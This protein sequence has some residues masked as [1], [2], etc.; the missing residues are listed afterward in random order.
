MNSYSYS[1]YA[2][3]SFCLNYAA[4]CGFGVSVADE[5]SLLPP[6]IA[7]V[8]FCIFFSAMS[9]FCRNKPVEE[10]SEHGSVVEVVEEVVEEVVVEEVP[11][12]D[13]A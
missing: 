1:Y 4:A 8:F 6:I 9:Y 10:G 3:G 13:P 11:C 5:G 2:S 7:L 12:A